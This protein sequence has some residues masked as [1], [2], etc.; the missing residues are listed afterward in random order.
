MY[1]EV[2]GTHK[3]SFGYPLC[4]HAVPLCLLCQAFMSFVPSYLFY[5]QSLWSVVTPS[6]C[7]FCTQ[8]LW[9]AFA[10]FAPNLYIP[11][12]HIAF[13]PSPYALCTLCTLYILCAFHIGGDGDTSI[14]HAVMS[15]AVRVGGD[16]KI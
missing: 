5:I 16:I 2:V 8:F 14:L 7:T 15:F 12:L 11:A 6:L 1:S 13:A 9:P 3:S 4:F 10:P